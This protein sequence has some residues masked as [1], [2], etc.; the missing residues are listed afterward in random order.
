MK[1]H[2]LMIV[3]LGLV[4]WA[5]NHAAGQDPLWLIHGTV[6][7][8]SGAAAVSV[9]LRLMK[10]AQEE[11]VVYTNQ[12]GRYGFFN[13][14]GRPSDYTLEVYYRGRLIKTITPQTLAGVQRGGRHDIRLDT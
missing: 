9:K 10:G 4:L 6:N 2:V 11:R 8:G 7:W 14:P 5:G 13:V 3:G 12:N 1:H